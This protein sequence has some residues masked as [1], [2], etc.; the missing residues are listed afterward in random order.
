MKKFDEMNIE[1]RKEIAVLFA[2]W[3]EQYTHEVIIRVMKKRDIIIDND[4]AMNLLIELK[5]REDKERKEFAH[6]I[7]NL[8]DEF[9]TF[10]E[11]NPHSNPSTHAESYRDVLYD[12]YI[13][14]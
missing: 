6:S 1:E 9:D 2:N 14:E 4:F 13:R 8:L 11:Y 3:L 5:E 10:K 12:M 7:G